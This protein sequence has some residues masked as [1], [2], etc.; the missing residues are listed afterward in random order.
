MDPP[1]SVPLAEVF[2]APFPL[3]LLVT[4]LG[5]SLALFPNRGELRISERILASMVLGVFCSVLGGLV[6]CALGVFGAGGVWIA[7]AIFAAAGFALAW[8]RGG[9]RDGWRIAPGELLSVRAVLGVVF[10]AVVVAAH[11]WRLTD[12]PTALAPVA[13]YYL[14]DIIELIHAGTIPSSTI[15]WGMEMNYETNKI[16]WYLAVGAW[17]LVSGLVD[18]P[19]IAIYQH[20]VWVAAGFAL[21]A[22]VLFS[23]LTRHPLAA[24]FGAVLL[25]V[26]PRI[27]LKL[28][29]LR[30]ESFGQFLLL[31]AMWAIHLTFRRN[32]VRWHV[33]TGVLMGVLITCHGV[34]AVIAVFWYAAVLINAAIR[35]PCSC[36]RRLKW[37]GLSAAIAVAIV[38]AAW[39]VASVTPVSGQ[40]ALS[41]PGEYRPYRGK[42]PTSAFKVMV[43]GR[44][45]KRAD[46]FR[47]PFTVGPFRPPDEIFTQL[48]RWAQTPLRFWP[49][50][51][52]K[53]WPVVFV[54]FALIMWKARRQKRMALSVPL[55]FGVLF[56]WGVAFAYNYHTSLPAEHPNRR[57]FMYLQVMMTVWIALFADL[58]IDRLRAR[59][60]R[61]LIHLPIAL[62]V[63][64]ALLIK[65]VQVA[66]EQLEKPASHVSGPTANGMLAMNYLREHT[67]PDSLVF[68]NGSSDG[69]IQVLAQRESIMEGRAP[70]FQPDNLR[71]VLK[72]LKRAQAYSR[73]ADD[74]DWLR[75]QGVDYVLI[76]G[77]RL[78]LRSF[79]TGGFDDEPPGLELVKLFG[80]VKVFR[81][82]DE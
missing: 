52:D 81:V 8:R 56:A 28:S 37:I 69:V 64:A 35:W 75:E 11:T 61:P 71:K 4:G 19:W 47:H 54:L 76:G 72:V 13:W 57:E 77:N 12:R 42:D 63:C 40:S 24:V 70:Y 48:R 18:K 1:V 62:A 21:A 36:L 39:T 38:G 3:L 25:V 6:L 26:L 34:P 66:V 2:L 60:R 16:G 53:S 46:D 58:A 59:F 80:K 74:V 44:S 55:F 20:V 14:G 82:L 67:P 79:P 7:A 51:S 30:G 15:D 33:L 17:N 49:H 65:P 45:E 50:K 78:A 23:R 68:T 9:L 29:C 5:W 10:V 43:F 73:D 22:W 32:A 27:L 31:A 41:S